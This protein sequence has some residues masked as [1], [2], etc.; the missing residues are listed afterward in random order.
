MSKS[1][2]HPLTSQVH[3]LRAQG[4]TQ[5]AIAD[6]LGILQGKVSRILNLES[7]RQ[8]ERESNRRYSARKCTAIADLTEQ[9]Y[10]AWIKDQS[11]T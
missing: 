8:N 4:F 7:Y 11:K 9:S 2:P 3:A 10:E 1:Q 6:M 5:Q